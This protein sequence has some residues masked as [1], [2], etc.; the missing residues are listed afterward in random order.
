[1]VLRGV[2]VILFPYSNLKTPNPDAPLSS[3]GFFKIKTGCPIEAFLFH[4]K[5]QQTSESKP[6]AQ[7]PA[8]QVEAIDWSG[9]SNADVW[10]T[11]VKGA[12]A[13]ASA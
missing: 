4:E 9:M 10:A 1:M 6:T 13:G 12:S 8:K 2:L 3:R 5:A 11:K 7:A